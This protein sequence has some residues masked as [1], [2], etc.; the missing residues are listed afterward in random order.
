MADPIFSRSW[1][2]DQYTEARKTLDPDAA[3]AHVA[4]ITGLDP[5]QVESVVASRE[6]VHSAAEVD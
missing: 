1:L 4:G 6:S 5:V 2:L 3:I